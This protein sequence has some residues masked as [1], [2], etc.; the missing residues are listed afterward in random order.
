MI[1]L[2]S[3]LIGG[4]L[5]IA[6]VGY[7]ALEVFSRYGD[8]PFMLMVLAVPLVAALAFMLQVMRR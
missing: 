2:L 7:V 6:G 5:L 4:T 1:R 8:D 3:W